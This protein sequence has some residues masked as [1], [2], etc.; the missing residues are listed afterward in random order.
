MSG[1]NDDAVN[2]LLKSKDT[3]PKAKT[4]IDPPAANVLHMFNLSLSSTLSIP[5][6]LYYGKTGLPFVPSVI[7]QLQL[8]NENAKSIIQSSSRDNNPL[9][10]F[11]A[12]LFI[13]ISGPSK[14]IQPGPN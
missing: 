5:I 6:Q 4:I 8:T 13:P 9:Y 12:K 3:L 1:D 2:N 14:M 10:L 7:N 11:A